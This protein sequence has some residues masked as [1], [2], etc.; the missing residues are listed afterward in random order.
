VDIRDDLPAGRRREIEEWHRTLATRTDAE[1]LNLA[2]DR[3]PKPAP[4][5]SRPASSSVPDAALRRARVEEALR[6][7][8]DLVMR[9]Q[10]EEAV[11]VLHEVLT[12]ADARQR[13][14]IRL[15]LA[16]AYAVDARWRRNAVALLRELV[17]QDANDA[18]ALAA[19]GGL[20]RRDGL[21]SRAESMFVRA[22][23]VD[24]GLAEARDGLRAVR[25]ALSARKTPSDTKRAQRRGLMSRL[26]SVAR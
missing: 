21:L 12:Q 7:A 8:E 19:L 25:T 18:E 11:S 16:R 4:M 9:Q 6:A 2:R 17:E 23:A 5:A 26:F 24:P 1:V 3:S 20:Y 14:H 10:A 15:L 13:R 22:V